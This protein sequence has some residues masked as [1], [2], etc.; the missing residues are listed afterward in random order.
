MKIVEAMKELR[1]IE[2]RMQ[3][4]ISY[5]DQYSSILNTERPEFGTEEDQKKEVAALL[6]SNKDLMA[7]YLKIKSSI[8]KTNL[9]TLVE[10]KGETKSI[11]EWLIIR[12]KLAKVMEMTY[13]ALS[14]NNAS[15]RMRMNMGSSDRTPQI[16]KMFDEKIK[17]EGLDKWQT[18][19]DNIDARLQ[20]INALTDIIE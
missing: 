12:R 14:S 15:N 3:S 18:M 19:S 10:I 20:V 5:L 13:S 1:T 6:Q 8:E 4:N 17:L 9:E 7:Q 11:G 2:K 16:I